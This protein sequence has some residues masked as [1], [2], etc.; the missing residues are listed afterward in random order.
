MAKCEEVNTDGTTVNVLKNVFVGCT[1]KI[2][3]NSVPSKEVRLNKGLRQRLI[4]PLCHR[5]FTND[6]PHILGHNHPGIMFY[7]QSFGAL[8][9]TNDVAAVASSKSATTLC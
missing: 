5:I 2:R 7:Y 1:T 9:Y 3:I 8:L 4:Y 6:P